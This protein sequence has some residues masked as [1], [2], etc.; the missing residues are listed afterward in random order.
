MSARKPKET[1]AAPTLTRLHQDSPAYLQSLRRYLGRQA[2]LAIDVIGN[3][4]I[5]GRETIALF[6]SAK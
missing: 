4:E 6:C 1:E 5:L 3:L 2:P